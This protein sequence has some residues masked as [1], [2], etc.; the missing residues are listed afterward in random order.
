MHLVKMSASSAGRQPDMRQQLL[1]THDPTSW[2]VVEAVYFVYRSYVPRPAGWAL[3]RTL[4]LPQT[5]AA[6]WTAQHMMKMCIWGLESM[7]GALQIPVLPQLTR[8]TC[9]CDEQLACPCLA[10]DI[11]WTGFRLLSWCRILP[12]R[13]SLHQ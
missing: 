3:G 6:L 5:L 1:H 9:T 10:N 7:V 4:A 2:H 11:S 12:A 13:P 8:V